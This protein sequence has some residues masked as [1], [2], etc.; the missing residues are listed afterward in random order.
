MLKGAWT[1]QSIE[2]V[3]NL[4]RDVF[5]FDDTFFQYRLKTH[6]QNAETISIH[7]IN[8]SATWDRYEVCR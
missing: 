1:Y 6:M 4:D 2:S 7:R 5:R 8:Y 3:G